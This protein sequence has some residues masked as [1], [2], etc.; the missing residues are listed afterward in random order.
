M[1]GKFLSSETPR[2]VICDVCT[3]ERYGIDGG[4]ELFVWV[5]VKSEKIDHVTGKAKKVVKKAA[6]KP[7]QPVVRCSLCRKTGHNFRACPLTTE[8]LH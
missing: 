2:E 6:A 1:V 8:V 3:R 4:E 7:R 5:R